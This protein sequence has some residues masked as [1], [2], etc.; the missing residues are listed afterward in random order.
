MKDKLDIIFLD[1]VLRE[2]LAKCLKYRL[3]NKS[4]LPFSEIV[5]EVC[6]DLVNID[7]QYKLVLHI[8]NNYN[9][10]LKDVLNLSSELFFQNL[11]NLIEEVDTISFLSEEEKNKKIY[12]AFETVIEKDREDIEKYSKDIK[13]V[14]NS[15]ENKEIKGI[16]LRKFSWIVKDENEKILLLEEALES[17]DDEL[18]RRLIYYELLQ[19]LVF[20]GYQQK[21]EVY[22]D[23][24]KS[25]FPDEDMFYEIYG[26]LGMFFMET[27]EK[28]KAKK[29]LSYVYQWLVYESL[30]QRINNISLNSNFLVFLT[31]LAKIYEDLEDVHEAEKVYDFTFYIIKNFLQDIYENEPEN[32]R[33]VLEDN[34]HS[35]LVEYAFFKSNINGEEP[36]TVFSHIKSDLL[37]ESKNI[38]PKLRTIIS[39]FEI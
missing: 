25:E 35:F 23:K 26:H 21:L 18:E 12:Q 24:A 22:L 13:K 38:N 19:L 20:S 15:I 14:I 11:V 30:D 27:D 6:A 29:Y 39:N 16:I 8:I 36:N 28:E 2:E 17:C 10:T 1:S 34:L 37:K 33:P 9:S 7:T 31:V 5:E 4:Y 32:I 3:I